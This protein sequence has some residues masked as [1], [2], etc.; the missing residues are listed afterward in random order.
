LAGSLTSLG[1]SA[2]FPRGPSGL[3]ATICAIWAKFPSVRVKWCSVRSRLHPSNSHRP[4]ARANSSRRVR[5]RRSDRLTLTTGAPVE[6]T[7][8]LVFLADAFRIMPSLHT[9]RVGRG[10]WPALKSNCRNVHF[11]VAG[12]RMRSSAET[13]FIVA[14][15]SLKRQLR[16]FQLLLCLLRGFKVFLRCGQRLVA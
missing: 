2:S 8:R 3:N 6:T 16:V 9:A 11:R 10:R 15:R 14:M 4:P 1:L 7:R 5:G 12:P 13:T